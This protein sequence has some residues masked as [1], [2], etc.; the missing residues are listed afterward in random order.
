MMVAD[1]YYWKRSLAML[2]AVALLMSLLPNGWL[3]FEAKAAGLNTTFVEDGIRYRVTGVATT[4]TDADGNEDEVGS[5]TAVALGP[6][7]GF[8]TNAWNNYSYYIPSMLYSEEG[9][10]EIAYFITGMT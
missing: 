7:T 8:G 5:Y 3:T 2:L 1:K 4:T 9:T 6:T 10:E